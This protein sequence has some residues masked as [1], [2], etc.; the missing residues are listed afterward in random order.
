MDAGARLQP[1][2]DGRHLV[3]VTIPP[4]ATGVSGTWATRYPPDLIH[5]IHATKG[6]FACDEIMREEDPNYV[7][8]SIRSDV[9]GYLDPSAFAGKRLLDFGCGAG[10]SLLVMS[11]LLPSCELVGVELQERLIKLA[12]LRAKH[13]GKGS[14]EVHL[15]PSGTAL[16][17]GIGDFDY[18]VFSA[19]YEHLLPKERTS[20]LPLLWA[21]LKPGGVLFLNQT[22]HRWSPL[23]AHTTG[24]PLINYLPDRLAYAMAKRFSRRIKESDDWQDLLR[25]GIRGGTTGE[26]L[27]LLG[28]SAALLEPRGEIGDR[29]DLWYGRLSPR[30][31]LLK[32]G[33]WALLK[34]LKPVGGIHLIPELSLAIR[35]R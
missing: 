32:R 8:R 15:S 11:R 9:L 13:L 4:G 26:I 35:K 25:A 6:Y 29:I 3:Q 27:G 10:A 17:D 2:P 22:P 12:R 14:V 34:T 7:E 20:L 30:R 19:V 5:A 24:L 28:D 31:R 23:E 16:P 21:H 18:I 33:A 1:L